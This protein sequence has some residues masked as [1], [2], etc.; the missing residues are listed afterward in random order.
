MNNH[1]VVGGTLSDSVLKTLATPSASKARNGPL[2]IGA[3]LVTSL[4]AHDTHGNSS[5]AEAA[6][7][8]PPEAGAA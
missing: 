2:A 4:D 7:K 6:A 8:P 3:L 5:H 1:V